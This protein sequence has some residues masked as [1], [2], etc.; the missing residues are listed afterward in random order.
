MFS[1]P[2]PWSH[3]GSDLSRAKAKAIAPFPSYVAQGS[4][5]SAGLACVSN[6]RSTR[7]LSVSP[8]N[9]PCG[10]KGH[11]RAWRVRI[12]CLVN[13]CPQIWK[14]AVSL[15]ALANDICFRLLA[16]VT[17][18]SLL[19]HPSPLCPVLPQLFSGNGGG[20]LGRVQL[21]LPDKAA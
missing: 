2:G 11:K 8:L 20:S 5:A 18:I 9:G 14:L 15:P 21:K 17:P 19:L 6:C 4:E 12:P 7:L 10:L 13:M 3:P 1:D 16:Y